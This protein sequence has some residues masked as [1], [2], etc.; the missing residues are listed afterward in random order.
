M[1]EEPGNQKTAAPRS[2]RTDEPGESTQQ[3]VATVL[4][5]YGT[6]PR[7]LALRA[8]I[9]AVPVIGGSIDVL[10]AGVGQAIAQQRV[11]RLFD[12][13]KV[14]MTD[15]Q[16]T[17]VD[18]AYL[19]SEEWWDLVRQA[20]EA[21]ARTRQG[22]KVRYYAQILK[23]AVS[24]RSEEDITAEEVLAIVSELSVRDIEI[25]IGLSRLGPEQPDDTV[26]RRLWIVNS[27]PAQLHEH[28]LPLFDGAVL[29]FALARLQRSGVIAPSDLPTTF[30]RI[31]M[32]YQETA[33]LRALVRYLEQTPSA[34]EVKHGPDAGGDNEGDDRSGTGGSPELPG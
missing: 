5:A 2:G 30:G 31:N 10:V 34:G 19:E 27:L 4:Q 26:S 25:A 15:L 12:E 6:N 23:G 17:R 20:I 11:E 21:A 13:L 29:S 18:Q 14:A 22:E 3:P 32:R 9:T 16:D 1:T 8:I 28:G 24:I 33:A 7:L